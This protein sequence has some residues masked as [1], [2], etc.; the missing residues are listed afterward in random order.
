MSRCSFI[1][2]R[3]A[4]TIQLFNQGMKSAEGILVSHSAENVLLTYRVW[5]GKGYGGSDR[6]MCVEGRL[7]GLEKRRS[8][9]K[10]EMV[11]WG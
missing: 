8:R 9:W 10:M 3:A 4:K 11:D 7:R 1:A 5:I 6:Y 2:G